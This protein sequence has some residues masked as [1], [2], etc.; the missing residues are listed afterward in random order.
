MID[1]P[2]FSE[3]KVIREC[4]DALPDPP[5]NRTL[6]D[7]GAQIGLWAIPYAKRNWNVVCYEAS[8]ANFQLLQEKIRQS[9]MNVTVVNK[10]VG[11]TDQRGIKFYFSDEF[12]GINSLKV[13]H[14]NLNADKYAIVEMTT[15]RSDL[16]LR[17]VTEV[18]LLKTDIEGADLL[19]LRG[20]DFER[21]RP[22]IVVSE[23]GSRSKAY[24]YGIEDLINFGGRIGY[25]TYVSSWTS[26]PAWRLGA[27]KTE[28]SLQYF[29]KFEPGVAL[30]WGDVIFVDSTIAS[31]FE[32]VAQPYLTE[33]P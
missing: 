21:C 16:P 22:L 25:S 15:L 4:F 11:D 19:A 1:Q 26:A 14:P 6:I 33:R 20:H 18:S 9:G 8:P 29:G 17:G 32:K 10:A 27:P 12:I 13:N 3:F 5:N 24:G 31:V 28:H 7:V 2:K 23:Y 30:N